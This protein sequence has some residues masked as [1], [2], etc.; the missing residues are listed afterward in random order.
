[1][2]IAG[3]LVLFLF[4]VMIG[5]WQGWW[6]GSVAVLLVIARILYYRDDQAFKRKIRAYHYRVEWKKTQAL[7]EAEQQRQQAMRIDAETNKVYFILDSTNNTVKI[8]VSQ[9]PIKRMADLQTSSPHPLT[10]LAVTLGGYEL[11]KKLHRRFARYRLSGEWFRMNDDLK[12]YIQLAK[13]G[14]DQ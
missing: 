1:M 14:Q 6:I 10:L 5:G 4:A 12:S 2:I 3:A 9:H 8:G 13:R 11:E 7:I